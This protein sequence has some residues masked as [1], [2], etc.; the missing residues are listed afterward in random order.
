MHRCPVGQH[1]WRSMVNKDESLA[2]AADALLLA[3]HTAT[4]SA[5]TAREARVETNCILCNDVS[6]ARIAATFAITAV[7]SRGSFVV[8]LTASARTGDPM[9]GCG[10]NGFLTFSSVINVL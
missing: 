3:R 10:I 4:K 2:A 5:K 8:A 1:V 7:V 9:H 6:L